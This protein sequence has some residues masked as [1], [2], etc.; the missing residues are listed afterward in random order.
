MPSSIE[1]TRK[2][3]KITAYEI[4]E[5]KYKETFDRHDALVSVINDCEEKL[6]DE[7]NIQDEEAIKEIQKI[8]NAFKV[9]LAPYKT[10]VKLIKAAMHTTVSKSNET[11]DSDCAEIINKN[12]KQTSFTSIE[13]SK[14]EELIN[15]EVEGEEKDN[16][17][18]IVDTPYSI[19]RVNDFAIIGEP[20][21]EVEIFNKYKVNNEYVDNKIEEQKEEIELENKH[22]EIE[23]AVKKVEKDAEAWRQSKEEPEESTIQPMSDEDRRGLRQSIFGDSPYEVE[24]RRKKEEETNAYSKVEGTPTYNVTDL[25]K[26]YHQND[27]IYVVDKE[28]YSH[29]IRDINIVDMFER[30]IEHKVIM[31]PLFKPADM[32]QENFNAKYETIDHIN[33][34]GMKNETFV[35]FLNESITGVS[36]INPVVD[37]SSENDNSIEILP[38][39]ENSIGVKNDTD[40]DSQF[41]EDEL[42]ATETGLIVGG[43]AIAATGLAM[44]GYYLFKNKNEETPKDEYI[45][46]ARLLQNEQSQFSINALINVAN[47]PKV[48][49]E[50]DE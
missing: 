36:S 43:S 33:K 7:N 2:Q 12:F 16:D 29:N 46:T 48:T 26:A 10:Q 4:M 1:I 21:P 47:K 6:N 31:G 8:Q 15:N 27:Y 3:N 24:K 41:E 39:D 13:S 34:E 49:T 5:N 25:Q 44:A 50:E 17:T 18:N 30:K 35:N 42:S 28:G 40:I 20:K 37:I 14:E 32:D 22:K 11:S 23:I 9:E 19:N 38:N 45:D